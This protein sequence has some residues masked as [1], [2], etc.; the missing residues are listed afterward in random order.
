MACRFTELIIDCK[1]PPRV[2]E[3]WR[4]VLGY[5]EGD[6]D[7]EGRWVEL[8]GGPEAG[9]ALLFLKVPDDKVVKNRLHIDV[10]PTDR[11]RDAEV[12]RIMALGARKVDIGQGEV[13]W[14]VLADPEDN[15]FCVLHS[16]VDP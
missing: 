11:D 9:P 3:F 2:A 12:E 15:E 4:N 6:R 7:P 8:K 10:N 1:E 5:Q 14:V 16:R 13:D